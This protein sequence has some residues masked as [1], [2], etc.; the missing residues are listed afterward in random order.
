MY[1]HIK[2]I[3]I[4]VLFSY[5]TTVVGCQQWRPRYTDSTIVLHYI[6]LD[7]VM[8]HCQKSVPLSTMARFNYD[9]LCSVCNDEESAICFLQDCGVLYC[10]RTYKKSRYV[11]TVC[12]S[13]PLWRYNISKCKDTTGI[14]INTLLDSYISEF[15]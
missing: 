4:M 10:N 8:F 12:G 14:R 1:V 11:I 3:N 6:Y 15:L 13:K 9:M 7:T 2:L 5:R